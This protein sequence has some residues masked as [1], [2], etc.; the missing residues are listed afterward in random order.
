MRPDYPYKYFDDKRVHYP[1]LIKA[2]ATYSSR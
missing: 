1:L 2:L